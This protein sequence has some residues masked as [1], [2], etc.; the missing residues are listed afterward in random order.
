MRQQLGDAPGDESEPSEDAAGDWLGAWDGR[1]DSQPPEKR[2][3][4][5]DVCVG[6]GGWVGRMAG[7]VVP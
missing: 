6:S 5:C 1:M 7:W 4:G 2:N 3:R